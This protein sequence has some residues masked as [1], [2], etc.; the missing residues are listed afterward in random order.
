[1]I[2]SGGSYGTTLGVVVAA[3][4]PDRMDK[5]VLDGVLNSHEYFHA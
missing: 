2:L 1:M 5:L 3:L 4:F